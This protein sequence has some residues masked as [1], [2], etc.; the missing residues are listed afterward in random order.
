MTA[1][2]KFKEVDVKRAVKG[3]QAAGVAVQRV[4]IDPS[5]KIDIVCGSPVNASKDSQEWDTVLET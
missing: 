4:S 2:A 5:G 3:V 1:P